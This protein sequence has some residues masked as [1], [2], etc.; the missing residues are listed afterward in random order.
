MTPEPEIISWSVLF[1]TTW[2]PRNWPPQTLTDL[3]DIWVVITI[4]VALGM[5]FWAM[6]RTAQVWLKTRAYLSLASH[7]ASDA[8]AFEKR[9]QWSSQKSCPLAREF[10]DLLVQV[11][12]SGSKDGQPL[13]K[14][15]KRSGSATEIFTTANL[16]EGIVGSR[17]L[18]ATPAI[19]T[20]L[21]VLGTFV[22]LAMGIGG[23]DLSSQNI[24]NLNQSI[25]PLIQGCSTAFITSVWGVF[26]SI[27]FTV[28]EKAL[29]WL[30]VKR[31]QKVQVAFDALVPR[32]TP[33]E[34]ML[35]LQRS[36]L[37]QEKIS[38]GL[39][40]A[41]GDA[42]QKA[43][44]RLGN[45]I[46]DAVKKTLG[47]GASDLA[48][49]SAEM[50][51]K[52]LTD[53]LV[54]LEDSMKEIST[55]FH[56][57]FGETNKNLT[58]TIS[59]FETVLSGVDATVK[60]S[61]SAVT[62]AV[63]GLT[64]LQTVVNALES[65]TKSLKEAAGQLNLLRDTFTLSAEKNQLAATAQQDAADKNK[66]VAIQFEAIGTQL[67][68]IQKEITNAAVVIGSISEP[69]G[70]LEKILRDTPATFR[71]EGEKRLKNE[72]DRTTR[73]LT[74]TDKL[75]DAVKDAAEKFSKVDGLAEHLQ[76][77][78][79]SLKSVSSSLTNLSDKISSASDKHLAAASASEKAAAAG[80]RTADKL[81]PIP[82]SVDT[83]AQTLSQAGVAI[84]SAAT[85]SNDVYSNL[86]VY[87][88]QWFDGVELGLLSMKDQLQSIIN[89]Y[90]K[91][92]DEETRK[93]FD[94]WTGA[95]NKSLGQFASLVNDLQEN[96]NELRQNMEDFNTN[97]GR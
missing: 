58:E 37:E 67:P 33:E 88:K 43:I 17:L 14:D 34:S 59:K 42:M 75:V 92:V 10:N 28:L 20:G 48:G 68:E 49:K 61:Q 1:P 80:E 8:G 52:A 86:I 83:L 36:S 12:R 4:G 54:K 73:L 97:G 84:K 41:I 77:S 81:A 71:E 76:N 90:G 11:P 5:L 72:D 46:T 23:L 31:I 30:S 55:Q 96:I 7:L 3:T 9:S 85:S 91:S 50:M 63:A 93:H 65:G 2:T 69:L 89:E 16:G 60:S 78:A 35:D 51:A 40:G 57:E 53:Q 13:D 64:G 79:N 39:A 15:F 32:Y 62:Q 74:E 95:V 21:G 94:A 26:A 45:S 38:K 24:N 56:S 47:D 44:D 27:L 25:A 22:G 87:Q 19:L 66:T 82:A 70:K 18:M 29:E 6:I